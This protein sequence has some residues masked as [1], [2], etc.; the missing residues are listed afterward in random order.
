MMNREIKIKSQSGITMIELLI[1]IVII[2]IVAAMAVPRFQIAIERMKFQSAVRDLESSL[3]T[4]RSNSISQKGQF[5]VYFDPSALTVTLF[6]DKINTSGYDFV[7]GDSVLSV[8]SLPVQFQ[9]LA[10]DVLGNVILF[11][12]NGSA[13]FN[14]GGNIVSLCSTSDVVGMSLTSI[15]ASTGRINSDVSIY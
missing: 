14:G 10:T 7:T 4:A 1:T 11:R 15:L 12:S 13:W 9:T 2:G 8:D 3:R 5:G 6:E